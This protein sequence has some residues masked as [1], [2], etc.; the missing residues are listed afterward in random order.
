VH[1]VEADVEIGFNL[2]D[3]A[4]EEFESGRSSVAE[5]VLRDADGVLEEIELRLSQLDTANRECFGPLIAELRREVS[6]AK[7]RRASS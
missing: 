5:R 2:V 1:L 6:V 7:S 3:M 4:R